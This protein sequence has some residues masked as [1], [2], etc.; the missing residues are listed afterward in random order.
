MGLAAQ[1]LYKQLQVFYCAS[2]SYP[3][4]QPLS[5][6]RLNNMRAHDLRKLV[7]ATKPCPNIHLYCVNDNVS[8]A[9]QYFHYKVNLSCPYPS[10]RKVLLHA[11]KCIHIHFMSNQSLIMGH[12]RNKF[13]S[14]NKFRELRYM[15]LA[16][17]KSG[18]ASTCFW[19]KVKKIHIYFEGNMRCFRAG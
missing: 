17:S 2:L 3:S 12:P 19:S 9:F 4:A 18:T 1:H 10:T 6:D 16:R 15:F 11:H 7:S 13:Y 5:A 14:E 8:W